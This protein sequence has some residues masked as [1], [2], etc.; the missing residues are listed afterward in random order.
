LNCD[1]VIFKARDDMKKIYDCSDCKHWKF[2][3]DIKDGW[4]DY[5]WQC[6]I[7]GIKFPNSYHRPPMWCPITIIKIIFYLVIIGIAVIVMYKI[8]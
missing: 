7:T 6:K 4:I 8:L 3:S 2:G 5:W 1:I